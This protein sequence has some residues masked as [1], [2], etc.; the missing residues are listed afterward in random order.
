LINGYV[1]EENCK[2]KRQLWE[3]YAYIICS[4]FNDASSVIKLGYIA[5]NER[6]SGK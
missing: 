2:G 1:S 4:S 3:T 5:S 6:M